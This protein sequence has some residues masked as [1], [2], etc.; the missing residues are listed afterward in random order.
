MTRSRPRLARH[1]RPSGT[2]VAQQLALHHPRQ[3]QPPQR[4]RPPPQQARL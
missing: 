3:K 4:R 1:V 2:L